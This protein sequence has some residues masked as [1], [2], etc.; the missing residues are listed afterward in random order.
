MHL[1]AVENLEH[2]IKGV[3]EGYERLVNLKPVTG[4]PISPSFL[5]STN[6]RQG[7]SWGLFGVNQGS[8]ESILF[9]GCNGLVIVGFPARFCKYTSL[10]PRTGKHKKG[11]KVGLETILSRGFM[12]M[13]CRVDGFDKPSMYSVIVQTNMIA[14]TKV[15]ARHRQSLEGYLDSVTHAAVMKG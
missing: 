7:S 1:R 4:I 12:R 14:Q 5:P 15:A 2:K 6:Q 3:E 13:A 9:G 11:S 8:K 10:L